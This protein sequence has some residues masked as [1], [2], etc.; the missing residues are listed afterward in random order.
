MASGALRRR[1]ARRTRLAVTVASPDGSGAP[2][3]GLGVWL[4]S[5]APA[6]A[7]GDV[8]VALV[9]DTRM[10]ALNR[11][12]R[13][14]HSATDVLSFPAYAKA[15]AGKSSGAS[16]GKPSGSERYL[17]DIVIAKGVAVRQAAA[18]GHRLS[19]ELRVLALHGLLHLLGYDHETDDGQMAR[20][21]ARLRKK[22]GLAAGL[23]GR[24]SAPRGRSARRRLGEGGR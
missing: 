4:S 17:G 9:S 21:E 20:A 15:P 23:I 1:P 22:G 19:V 5:V 13:G 18:A 2:L 16:P 14:K 6:S 8:T 24:K 7:H 12:F 10:R 11:A 3:R